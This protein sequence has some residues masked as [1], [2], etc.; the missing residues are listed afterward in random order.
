ML[1]GTGEGL[2]D[3]EEPGPVELTGSGFSCTF[4]W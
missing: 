1:T 2:P 3:P 4:A